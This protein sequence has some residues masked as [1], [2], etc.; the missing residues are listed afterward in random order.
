MADINVERKGP[1]IWPWIIGL[2]V[3]A[4]LIWA[5]AEMVDTDQPEVATVERVEQ[6][7]A[8]VPAPVPAEPQPGAA[9]DIGT[10]LP[11]G[12][13]DVG[14][15]VMVSGTVVGQP[16]QDG[17]WIQPTS[18]QNEVFFVRSPA[19]TS[20]GQPLDASSLSSGQQ[21]SIMGTIEQASASQVNTWIEQSQ[22]R[23]ASGFENW[24]VHTDYMIGSAQTGMPGQQ[25]GMQQ[26]Q[27]QQQT[28]PGDTTQGQY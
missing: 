17:F 15:Q 18:A 28:R 16:T 22:L 14:R 7:P 23:S 20:T 11:L 12:A 13:D 8:A 2:L 9:A 6:E 21:V 24:N 10:V 25:P 3:L 4:L 5:I 27:G 19:H 1:S 26:Q